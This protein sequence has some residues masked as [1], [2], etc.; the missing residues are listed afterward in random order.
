M[1]K[2]ILIVKNLIILFRPH[3]WVKN[4][5]IFLPLFFDRRI[6]SQPELK[7][8][9]LTFFIFSLIASSIYCL[10]DLIDI[11]SDK[12]HP[13]K[14]KRPLASGLIS[15]YFAIASTLILF[16]IALF[17]FILSGLSS[18]VAYLILFYLIMN[19]AYSLKLKRIA[20]LDIMII[21]VGFVLRLVIG[22]LASNTALSHWIVIMTFLLAL[23]LA[24]AKRRDDYLIFMNTGIKPRSNI[25]KYNAEY[26]NTS[27]SIITAVMLVSYIMYT[28]SSEVIAHIGNS[29]LYITSLFVILGMLRYL[30]LTIVDEV[31]GSPTEVVL[32]DKFIQLTLIGWILLF[33]YF[34]YW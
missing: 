25:N 10:N 19:I 17:T 32:T 7:N 27:L 3:Q 21:S 12:L 34:L 8:T 9:F 29:N 2:Q 13:K 33:A 15:K 31:S 30:Q 4:F 14:C 23:F 6:T 20:I 18:G 1:K 24:L 22:G 11:E 5:F 28:V 16:C 26:I